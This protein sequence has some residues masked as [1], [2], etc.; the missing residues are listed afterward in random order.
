MR[1][2]R[3]SGRLALFAILGVIISACHSPGRRTD[4]PASQPAGDVQAG[5]AVFQARCIQ[6]HTAVGLRGAENRIRTNLGSLN[7]Q[8]RGMHLTDRE[9]AD[10]KAYIAAR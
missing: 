5:A 9:V 3:W 10:L 8:M 7:R 1:M 4:P 6:C 2:G